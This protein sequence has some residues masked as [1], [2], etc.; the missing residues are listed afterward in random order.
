VRGLDSLS[1]AMIRATTYGRRQSHD[2]Q[3]VVNIDHIRY[4]LASSF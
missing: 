3:E 1:F 4:R 2:G